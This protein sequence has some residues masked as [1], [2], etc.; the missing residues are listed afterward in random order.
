[1]YKLIG[2]ACACFFVWQLLGAWR[3][4]VV[5]GQGWWGRIRYFQRDD[6]PWHFYSTVF[7]YVLGTL[8]ALLL[9]FVF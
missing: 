1:M 4:G 2:L 8:L 5:M 9:L 3:N 7:S 6:E